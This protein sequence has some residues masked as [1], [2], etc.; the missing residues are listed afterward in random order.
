MFRVVLVAVFPLAFV[1]IGTAVCV[2]GRRARRVHLGG[3]A[4][5]VTD[6]AV[7]VRNVLWTRRYP[8]EAISVGE[9]YEPIRF[10][11]IGALGDAVVY[12]GISA[13]TS[14]S[15][16]HPTP[17]RILALGSRSLG[18]G[19]IEQFRDALDAARRGSR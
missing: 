19:V 10:H 3:V 14:R 1:A 18:D 2:T 6:D 17:L 11:V 7:V 16:K 12:T 13:T 5:V 4:L 9:Y 15:R 8:L